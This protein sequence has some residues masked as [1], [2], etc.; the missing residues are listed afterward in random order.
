MHDSVKDGISSSG[1]LLEYVDA[2]VIDNQQVSLR[3]L[4]EETMQSA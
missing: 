4:G 3:Q 2:K 1:I